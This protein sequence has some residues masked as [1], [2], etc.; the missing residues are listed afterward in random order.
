MRIKSSAKRFWPKI[1]AQIAKRRASR[2]TRGR[3]KPKG[4]FFILHTDGGGRE[5]PSLLSLA[6]VVRLRRDGAQ[7]ERLNA[8]EC[9][10]GDRK[11]KSQFST[12]CGKS[13]GETARDYTSLLAKTLRQR[14]S[15]QAF[16]TY[17]GENQPDS[18]ISSASVARALRR[19][20]I[21]F[22]KASTSSGNFPSGQVRETPP[23]PL[24]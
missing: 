7:V 12:F 6:S 8:I 21:Y 10:K 5:S 15:S 24:Q 9:E 16:Y 3:A 19:S 20:R 4:T 13:C 1:P 17:C 18:L 22:T 14:D 23:T 2:S 11:R